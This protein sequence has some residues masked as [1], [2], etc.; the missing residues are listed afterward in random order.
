MKISESPIDHNLSNIGNF[1]NF[2][3]NYDPHRTNRSDLARVIKLLQEKEVELAYIDRQNSKLLK[4][5]TSDGVINNHDLGNTIE[6]INPKSDVVI[7]IAQSVRDGYRAG[8]RGIDISKMRDGVEF[9][10]D[11]EKKG[12]ELN[13]DNVKAYMTRLIKE[14]PNSNTIYS[15]VKSRA[16]QIATVGVVTVALLT[17][18]SMIDEN[19]NQAKIHILQKDL[20]SAHIVLKDITGLDGKELISY[21]NQK[22]HEALKNDLVIENNAPF[23]GVLGSQSRNIY[24]QVLTDQSY[25][26]LADGTVKEIDPEK[27]A[28]LAELKKAKIGLYYNQG[29]KSWNSFSMKDPKNNSGQVS[30]KSA[31]A[32]DR[33]HSLANIL[34]NYAP[35]AV[36]VYNQ[37]ILKPNQSVIKR[38]DIAGVI[39][40]DSLKSYENSLLNQ[41]SVGEFAKLDRIESEKAAMKLIEDGA[42]GTM[43]DAVKKLKDRGFDMCGM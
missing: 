36:L 11:L 37:H 39:V 43:D 13:Y 1:A 18:K 14:I 30:I 8:C 20:N 33:S 42:A 34:A 26:V 19:S 6:N 31:V 12:K 4:L 3:D 28:D 16:K 2:K 24:G 29:T 35:S 25:L 21:I 5:F 40:N 15:Y 41:C 38:G 32:E 22:N 17:G 7:A 10:V 27:E 23:I 9:M